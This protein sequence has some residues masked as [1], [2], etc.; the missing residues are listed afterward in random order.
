MKR[1]DIARQTSEPMIGHL[2]KPTAS[3]KAGVAPAVSQPPASQSPVGQSPAGRLTANQLTASPS[4]ANRPE[5]TPCYRL[6]KRLSQEV[7]KRT[8]LATDIHSNAAVI[9][10]LLL[11]CP[12]PQEEEIEAAR[13]QSQETS[14]HTYQ[15]PVTLPYLDSFETETALGVALAL[16]KPYVHQSAT[17]QPISTRSTR[18]VRP[19]TATRSQTAAR[20]QVTATPQTAYADFKVKSSSDKISI[21]CLESRI[22]AGIVSDD[23]NNGLEYWLLAVVGTIAFVGGTVATTGSI[24]LGIVVAALLPILFRYAT[25]PKRDRRTKRQAI[26]RLSNESQGRTFLS[27][28]TALMPKRNR[29][30]QVN[31]PPLESKLHYSRLSVKDVTIAPA[32]FVNGQNLSGA[33]L[34]FTFY[35]HD[36]PSPRLCIVGSYQEI[37]WIHRHLLRWAKAD[38]SN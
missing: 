27:L 9:V 7:G 11:Y 2:I 1:Y 34:T 36:A 20:S 29:I 32:F 13:L 18:K 30:G 6:E 3:F 4:S 37:R 8:F 25:R 24:G 35:N 23:T 33:K 17:P 15:L 28:T 21:Q 16:V 19:A 38:S 12:D 10:K 26:V 14:L 31:A 5:A 22:W